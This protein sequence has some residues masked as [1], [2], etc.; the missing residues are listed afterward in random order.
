MKTKLKAI[1]VILF[2]TPICAWEYLHSSGKE[3]RNLLILGFGFQLAFLLAFKLLLGICI[4]PCLILTIVCTLAHTALCDI[5]T[6]S[7]FNE[8]VNYVP[9]KLYNKNDD[10]EMSIYCSF[11][12]PNIKIGK[13]YY[14]VFKNKASAFIVTHIAW[15]INK[16]NLVNEQVKIYFVV[17]TPDGKNHEYTIDEFHSLFTHI[18]ESKDDYL[19]ACA[20]GN[21]SKEIKEVYFINTE[22]YSQIQTDPN[23]HINYSH[24]KFNS[25]IIKNNEVHINRLNFRMFWFDRF[26]VHYKPSG[27]NIVSKTDAN[28]NL[29]SVIDF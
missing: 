15:A 5:L 3:C 19:D 12:I 16:Y 11:D 22:Y 1:L 23:L 24:V 29:L 10:K 20:T 9:P 21:F 7:T 27:D 17:Q 6:S 28:K 4:V 14:T 18:F 2:C 25:G 8:Q 13:K 26:G